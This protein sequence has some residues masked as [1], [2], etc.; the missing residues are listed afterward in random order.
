MKTLLAALILSGATVTFSQTPDPRDSIIIENRLTTRYYGMC[1]SAI[2]RIRVWITNKDSLEN[3]TLPLEIRASY[4][5]GYATL[6]RPADC[7][8]YTTASA[9]SVL[10]P[11]GQ[12][13][14]QDG[15]FE[16]YDGSP[17]DTFMFE[18]SSDPTQ[19]ASK[20]PPN[21]TRRAL[22]DI[23]FD[24][25]KGGGG[26]CPIDSTLFPP[27]STI[28]FTNAAGYKVPVNFV[29]GYISIIAHPPFI[30][31]CPSNPFELLYGQTLSYQFTSFEGPATWSIFSGPGSIDPNSGVY[32][33]TGQCHLCTL[34]V[35]IRATNQFGDIQD[36]LFLI[37]VGPKGDLNWDGILSS[38]DVVLMLNCALLG[39]PPP[40]DAGLCDLNCDGVTTAAD[41]VLH[42]N[43]TYL[44]F[45]FPC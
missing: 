45:P 32:T 25:I 33:Y 5:A 41:V 8:P 2:W 13:P 38:A 28:S 31:N 42:L 14:F 10:L 34:P 6:S 17:P 27:S 39:I 11:A 3:I 9:F 16:L 43:A 7:G 29:E 35:Q 30:S 40:V 44:G 15:R 1:G 4:Q 18:A 19:E 24:T 12:L 26:P 22:I 36:C 21:S 37:A 23:K 20:V